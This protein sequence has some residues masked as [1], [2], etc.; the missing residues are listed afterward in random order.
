M[1]LEMLVCEVLDVSEEV[2][3]K[4]KQECVSHVPRRS[5]D[6]SP[7]DCLI[8]SGRQ[9][10][11]PAGWGW[12]VPK[13]RN[14]NPSCLSDG[15][16]PSASAVLAVHLFGFKMSNQRCFSEPRSWTS[17][18]GHPF[19]KNSFSKVLMQAFRHRAC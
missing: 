2:E 11:L 17:L 7:P 15:R 13:R 10:A 8:I 4:Q 6:P 16:D 3:G 14:A 9:L 5:L 18:F 12:L 1:M 19:C